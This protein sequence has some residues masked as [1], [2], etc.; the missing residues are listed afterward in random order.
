MVEAGEAG[1]IL[2]DVLDRIAAM[3]EKNAENRAKV[4]SATL[5]PKIVVGALV[6]A[7]TVLMYYVVPRFVKM[8]S[9][10]NVP[11][12]LPTR[13]LIHISNAFTSYWHVGIIAVAASFVGGG[14]TIPTPSGRLRWD[15]LK[16]RFPIFGPYS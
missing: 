2:E 10:F 7:I 5:Y 6:I 3:L 4:K 13:M 11:L 14:F 16:L 15:G 1:G 12:P 8:Y 9:S